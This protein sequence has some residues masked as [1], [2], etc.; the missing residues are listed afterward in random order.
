MKKIIIFS[1]FLLVPI[2]LIAQTTITESLVKKILKES[3]IKKK[4][5]RFTM[6]SDQSWNFSNN[7]SLYYK[8]DT[9]N[10]IYYKSGKHKSHCESIIWTFYRKNAFI[11][12]SESLCKEPA[13]RSVTKYPQDYFT[14]AIYKVE[15]EIMIDF[16]DQNKIIVESFKILEINNNN[17]YDEIILKRR[18]K[19]QFVN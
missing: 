8:Q 13:T 14:I 7:D 12:G 11:L 4:N 1:L 3:I 6:S 9:I 16:F 15:D 18:F 17:D 10:A 19:P 2:C 5:G